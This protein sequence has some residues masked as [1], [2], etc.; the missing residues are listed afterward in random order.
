MTKSDTLQHATVRVRGE[1]S[2]ARAF[3][4]T[5]KTLE[6]ARGY[7]GLLAVMNDSRY[8][9]FF[10]TSLAGN[11]RLFFVSLGTLLDT[12]K[13]SLGIFGIASLLTQHG[14]NDLAKEIDQMKINH[15]STI[16]GIRH[17]RNKSIAHNSF[18]ATDAIFKAAAVTL[19]QI[20][21][22]IDSICNIVNK[23]TKTFGSQNSISEGRRNENAIQSV[24]SALLAI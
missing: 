17:I 5:W 4:H 1:A 7:D 13:G 12:R 22:L 3:F 18:E 24:L 15:R 9:D 8:T 23:I 19:D 16:E 20:E 21:A 11:L 2:A 10:L 14:Y 6:L